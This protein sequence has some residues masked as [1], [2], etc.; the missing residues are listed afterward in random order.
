MAAPG[1]EPIAVIGMACRFP[2]SSD[3]P[4]KLWDLLKSPRNLSKRVPV[5]RFDVTGF[6]HAN[7]SQHG[8]TDATNAYFIEDDVTRFDS[9]FFNIQPAEAEAIDPQQRLLMETVYDSMYVFLCHYFLPKLNR[10]LH[11]KRRR[12]DYREPPGNEHGRIR[13]PDV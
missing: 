1:P 12:T 5:D 11:Q 4:S 2:G 9:A 13:W 3:S 8:A 10:L 6:H 7:G